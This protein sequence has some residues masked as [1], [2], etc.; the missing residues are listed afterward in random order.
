VSGTARR[1]GLDP[2]ATLGS[3]V[4][5]QHA[6]DFFQNLPAGNN[7]AARAASQQTPSQ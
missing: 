1:A 6:V 5:R 4:T 2:A 3:M 7:P